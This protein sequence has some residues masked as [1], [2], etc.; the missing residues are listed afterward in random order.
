MKYV[1][2]ASPNYRDTKIST[3]T[4]MR[5]LTIGLLVVFAFGLY[6]QYVT[7]GMDNV[8]HS[9]MMMGAAIVSVLVTEAIWALCLK[10]DLKNTLL[11]SYG[12]VTAI[13]F[14]LMCQSNLPIYVVVVCS[15]LA[16]LFGKLL[17]GGFGHNIFNPAAVARAF[18]FASFAGKTVVDVVSKS[19]PT[20]TLANAGWLATSAENFN[21]FLTSFGGI[22]NMALGLYPGAIGETSALVIILVGLFLVVRRV[23]DWRVPVTYIVTLFVLALGLGLMQGQP[24]TYALYHVLTGGAMFGAVFM[25]TD[26]VTSPTSAG[27]R[28]FFAMGA[29]IVTFVIRIGASLPEG[30]L[31]SILIMNMLTPLIENLFDGVQIDDK[32]KNIRN[33]A[34]LAV[35]GLV[36]MASMNA[37]AAPVETTFGETG[38]FTVSLKDVADGSYTGKGQ[39]MG[40]DVIVSFDVKGGKVTSLTIDASKETPGLGD[41][42]AQ[43]IT[44][45]VLAS[46]DI[47]F[48]TV[49]GATITSKAIQ[50]GF[51]TAIGGNGNA[52]TSESETVATDLPEA[53][54]QTIT[55]DLSAVA[56]GE[57]T[58][59]ATGMGEVSVTVT[60]EG[61]KIASAT[62][63]GDGETE[64]LGSPVIDGAA[65]QIVANQGEIEVVSGATVTSNAVNDALSSALAG[66]E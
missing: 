39:G 17:F 21:E 2:N 63:V 40:G 50:T 10:K 62:V 22:G 34:I 1:F 7:Y 35:V 49:V 58:G 11:H 65:D 66:G 64:G 43:T 13:I 12:W 46:G 47:S 32:K 52:S 31:Y 59:S 19:T 42:A 37:L 57:Y 54:N 29:A 18:V 26:P 45:T 30:V 20:G 27:G 61:G 16:I 60:V 6:N 23:I 5:D 28:I 38:A 48:D 9:L 3:D 51:E 33:N 14:V 25:L 24:L 36:L 44:D 41:T 15:V 53:E 55:I 4:I 8:M 56:D